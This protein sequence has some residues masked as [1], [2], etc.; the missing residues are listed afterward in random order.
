LKQQKQDYAVDLPA[1]CAEHDFT[2]FKRFLEQ[3]TIA[4][5][6]S[7]ANSYQDFNTNKLIVVNAQLPPTKKR[8]AVATE[9]AHQMIPRCAGQ[10]D[11]NAP[12]Y[13]KNTGKNDKSDQAAR[14]FALHMLMPESSVMDALEKIHLQ[15]QRIG[16]APRRNTLLARWFQVSESD[17]KWRIQ[18]INFTNTNQ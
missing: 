1:L 16:R 2:I 12:Y 3:N 4:F 6:V 18:Q 17:V 11:A 8:V 5:S 9:L 15:T 13:H 7:Q 14:F 10:M